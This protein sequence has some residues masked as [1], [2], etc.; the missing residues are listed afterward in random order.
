MTSVSCGCTTQ[1]PGREC[2][3]G[4]KLYAAASR[5]FQDLFNGKT[6]TDDERWIIYSL[7]RLA[8][9]DHLNG[10]K[11]GD[12][13][14]QRRAGFGM[15]FTRFCGQWIFQFGTKNDVLLVDW[16][17]NR[18]YQLLV[19][20][21]N[22]RPRDQLLGYYRMYRKNDPKTSEGKMFPVQAIPGYPVSS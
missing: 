17:R 22:T 7:S 16:L 14:I 18:G 13:K 10:W 1:G 2:T 12:V 20:V 19:Q 3:D 6:I 8:Y 21:K 4:G 11:D 9:I 5:A 15:V